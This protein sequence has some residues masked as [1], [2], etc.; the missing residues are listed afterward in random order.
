MG[1]NFIISLILTCIFT[2]WIEESLCISLIWQILAIITAYFAGVGNLFTTLLVMK[3]KSVMYG[4][5]QNLQSILLFFF[6][7]NSATL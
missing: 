7:L 1:F 6:T 4:I 3:E 5:I 2:V